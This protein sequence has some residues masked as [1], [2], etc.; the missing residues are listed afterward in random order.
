[1]DVSETGVGAAIK[2]WIGSF[3]D[4]SNVISVLSLTSKGI[5]D[6]RVNVGGEFSHRCWKWE[7]HSV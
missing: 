7:K 4:G 3:G 2:F 6:L 5:T 1:M